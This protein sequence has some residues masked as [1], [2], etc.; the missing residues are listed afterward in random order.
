MK[1][2]K[3]KIS[4]LDKAKQIIRQQG[5]VIRTTHAIQAGIHPRTLY[6]LRDDDQLE[7]LSR[8]VY[9]LTEQAAVSDPDMVIVA[10]RIP[11]AVNCLVSALS[12]HEMTTQIPHTV[13]IALQRGSDTPRLEYPPISIHRFSKE[14]LLTGITVHQIDNVP[15]R[16][17]SPEKTLADCF[18]FRNKIGMDVVL[19]ALKLYKT[20]K[21]FKSGEILKYAR[22][23]RVEKIIR[24]YLEM[25]T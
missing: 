25:I 24:P 18:K 3:N 14:A 8:G 16:I 1:Q 13:S 12:F 20:R 10:T 4:A 19:E 17:Y 23:C 15:V 11:K 2:I 6:Q 9:R 7:Q 5:G 22:I 21:E